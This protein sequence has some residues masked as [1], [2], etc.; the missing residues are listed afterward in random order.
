MLAKVE[1]NQP[2]NRDPLLSSWVGAFG[3]VLLY[4]PRMFA[5][6]FKNGL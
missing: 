1:R 6:F 3:D 5:S 4:V 2:R